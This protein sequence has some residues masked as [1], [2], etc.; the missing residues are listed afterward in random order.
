[1]IF[2]TKKVEEKQHII[3]QALS[4]VFLVTSWGME[5]IIG[6]LGFLRHSPL[7]LKC[8]LIWQMKVHVRNI[9]QK[10]EPALTARHS[11][12]SSIYCQMLA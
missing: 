5:Q 11:K 12:I 2:K 3:D 9:S 10:K 8:F 1:M 4:K 6:F 7:T